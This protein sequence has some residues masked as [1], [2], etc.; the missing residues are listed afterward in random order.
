MR[1]MS[2]AMSLVLLAAMVGCVEKGQTFSED[3][4]MMNAW[5]VDMYHADMINNAILTEHTLYPHHF[6]HNA[7]VLN[8]LGE[9]DLDVLAR[10][11]ADYPGQ[12]NVRQGVVEDELYQ[13]RL[14]TVVEYMRSRGV[15]TDRVKMEDRFSGGSGLPAEQ[16]LTILAKDV[17]VSYDDS[18]S[19]TATK[20]E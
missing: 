2:F 17:D 9:H 19:T 6:V 14:R 8:E 13:A 11:Y 5:S 16:V 20:S 4:A 15:D 12:M 7:A 1:M 10:H 18:G 3:R